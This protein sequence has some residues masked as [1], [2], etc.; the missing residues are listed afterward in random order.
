MNLGTLMHLLS[1]DG[2]PLIDATAVAVGHSQIPSQIARPLISTKPY[3]LDSLQGKW[4]DSAGYLEDGMDDLR[5]T[6]ASI[7]VEW[8]TPDSF[9]SY[10]GRVHDVLVAQREAMR[11]LDGIVKD[12]KDTLEA[13]KEAAKSSVSETETAIR[14][15]L[16]GAIVGIFTGGITGVLIGILVGLVSAFIAK[17]MA[18]AKRVNN[19]FRSI[20]G[21]IAR[22]NDLISGEKLHDIVPPPLPSIKWSGY[23]SIHEVM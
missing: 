6:V 12:L 16:I 23:H 19:E 13:A 10:T 3:T 4:G 1:L 2:L 5:Q 18:L 20:D 8:N 14:N 22:L 9:R 7:L 17:N 11:A 15:M 21:A